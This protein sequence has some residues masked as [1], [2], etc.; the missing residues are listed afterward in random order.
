VVPNG[1]SRDA[2]LWEVWR[3][4]CGF[5]PMLAVVLQPRA[6]AAAAARRGPIPKQYSVEFPEGSGEDPDSSPR[7]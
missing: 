5:V 3:G 4:G 7:S 1:P 6:A 2:G